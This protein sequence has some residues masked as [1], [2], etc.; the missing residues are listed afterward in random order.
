MKKITDITIDPDWPIGYVRYS[1]ADLSG[2]FDLVRDREGIV[3][4]RGFGAADDR[5]YG[6]T[7]DLGPGEDIVAIEILNIDDP[8]E[9]ALARDYAADNGLAFP[10]D[11]RAAAARSPAA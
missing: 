8:L 10:D 3:R 5:Y 2:S 7:V 4:E 9:V 1:N 6:V 11:I